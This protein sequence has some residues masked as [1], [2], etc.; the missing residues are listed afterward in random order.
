MSFKVFNNLYG[1][2]DYC[3]LRDKFSLLQSLRQ[4]SSGRNEFDESAA[5]ESCG[6]EE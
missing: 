5:S 6:S 2:L 3:M 1:M 4:F